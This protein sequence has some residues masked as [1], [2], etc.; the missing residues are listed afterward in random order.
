MGPNLTVISQSK[1]EEIDAH[2]LKITI[3]ALIGA[4]LGIFTTYYFNQFLQLA[5]YIYLT[6]SFI[7][8]AFFVV[9]AVL[10]A[11]FIKSSARLETILAF[12]VLVALSIFYNHLYPSPSLALIGGGVIFFMFLGTAVARGKKTI[13]NSL[14]VNF[15]SVA[16]TV[17]PRAI[18]GVLIFL[19][20]IIYLNYFEWGKFNEIIGK[21]LV[22]EILTASN[23][24]VNLFFTGVSFDQ[25][26]HIFL[27]GIV[28]SQINQQPP[29]SDIISRSGNN[30]LDD[31][32]SLPSELKD[33]FINESVVNLQKS[34]VGFVG[35]F[36]VTKN[37]KEVA[38]DLI[39]GQIDKL[40]AQ[41]KSIL[42]LVVAFVAFL[43]LKSFAVLF[44]W[45]IEFLAFFVFKFLV[46]INFAH[47]GL[48]TRSREFVILS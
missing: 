3:L 17:V 31:F 20:V 22:S 10:N 38:Y 12:Q 14:K 11:V 13:D 33:K 45:L 24:I 25:S 48:Q 21:K 4:A 30:F 8:G 44:Y 35:P 26:T 27:K 1:E 32:K 37:A 41:V 2:P 34:I 6:I 5:D 47:F 19:S 23:P 40:S 36:D 39:K 29:Q 46:A 42:G 28:Q 18:S 15:F 43:M 16:K 9:F 7:F